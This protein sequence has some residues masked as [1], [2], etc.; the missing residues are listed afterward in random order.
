L[1]RIVD[2]KNQTIKFEYDAAHQLTKKYFPEETV[3]YAYDTGGNLTSLQDSDSKLS[4]TYDKLNLLTKAQTLSGGL[5]PTTSISYTYDN[6]N[7]RATLVDVGGTTFKYVYDNLNR[8][9][10]ITN[11]AGTT[12]FGNYAYDVLSRRTGLTYPNSTSA[13]YTYDLAS[14]LTNLTNLLNPTSPTIFSQFDYIYNNVGYRDTMTTLTGQHNYSYDDLYRLTNADHPDSSDENYNYDEVGNRLLSTS[15]QSNL[16]LFSKKINF[17]AIWTYNTANQLLDDGT[18]TYEY[19][20]NGNMIAKTHDTSHN[21]ISY[22]YNSENQLTQITS[23]SN[24]YKYAY[25]GL[26]RRIEK[27]LVFGLSSEVTRYVYD[28]EDIVAEYS[29]TSTTPAATYLHGPGID[30]P[31]YMSRGGQTYYYHA[32]GLGSITELTNSTGAIAQTYK[33]DAFGNILSQTGS[34]INPFTYTGREFD[35]ESGLLYYRA[36]YMD[37]RIGRFLQEDP[38]P[39]IIIKPQTLNRYPYTAN[40]PINFTDPTG[41]IIPGDPDPSDEILLAI[42]IKKLISKIPWDKVTQIIKETFKTPCTKQIIS[43]F[44]LD[45]KTIAVFHEIWQKTK[46]GIWQIIHRDFKGPLP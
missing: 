44:K 46:E 29:G 6:N 9:T 31:I 3:T 24:T 8:L 25:D 32:D 21:V 34:L 45:G 16:G 42:F 38:N 17:Q 23:G 4:F 18:Y 20:N 41:L 5:Q 27:S 15:L 13:S 7:N 30:E 22:T 35:S 37:P 1:G 12:T 10:K 43:K 28:N 39:G 26:G 40:N 11:S 19:D 2:A 33:Y 14:Q 36:R